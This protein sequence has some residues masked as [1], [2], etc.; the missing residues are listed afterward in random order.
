VQEQLKANGTVVDEE[1]LLM[2]P[3]KKFGTN[4]Q[5]KDSTVLLQTMW[6]QY[7]Q[8]NGKNCQGQECCW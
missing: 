6:K 2:H 4:N 3:I 7:Q 5:L 1:K 8:Q